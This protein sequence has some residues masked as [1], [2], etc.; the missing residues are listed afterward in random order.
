MMR[1]CWI[2][3]LGLELTQLATA[4][5]LQH[6]PN[7]AFSQWNGPEP[8]GWVTNNVYDEQGK[9]LRALVVQASTAGAALR[10]NRTIHRAEVP[11]L[12]AFEGGM[13]SSRLVPFM[14]TADKPVRL[15]IRYQF[16]P[17]SADILR[18]D[19]ILDSR[20]TEPG[21]LK[22]D[23]TCDCQ[24]KSA[25]GSGSVVLPATPTS[26][27]VTFEA[28]FTN[29]A[30]SAIAPPGCAVYVWKIRFWLENKTTHLHEATTAVIEQVEILP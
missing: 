14:P 1:C 4:Q 28:V 9:L 16:I 25:L 21:T 20:N 24:L 27:T 3:A 7:A 2:I 19:L 29:P 17:D 11:A 5:P 18:T 12:V 10:V 26:Q 30:N 15:Q 8:V 23:N 13:L 22:P 6:I